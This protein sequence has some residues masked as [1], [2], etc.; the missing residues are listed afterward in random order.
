MRPRLLFPDHDL[1]EA[2]DLP[3]HAEDVAVDLGLD[4]LV[5]AMAGSDAYL[6]DVAQQVLLS[7]VTDPDVIAYRQA[8]LRD[9]LTNPQ[10][11]EQ[12][13]GLAM[14]AIAS[15]ADVYP[16]LGRNASS[17]LHR[18][19]Q[20]IEAMLEVLRELREL[21]DEQADA[22]GSEAFTH[23]FG[24]LRAE[25]DEDFFDTAED[26][27][28]RLRFPGGV[29]V[30]ARLGRGGRGTG[31]VLREPP[32]QRSWTR[33]VVAGVPGANVVEVANRDRSAVKA[34]TEL[35]ER[36]LEQVARSL[37]RSSQ[38]LSR[39]FA[40]LRREVG[41]YLG[42]IRL[43]DAL[44]RRGE[45]VFPEVAT[46]DEP[47]FV[48]AGLEDA[49]LRLRIDDP[50]V[51]NDVAA[52]GRRLVLITGAN[53]GG[54]STFLRA[55]GL[56]QLMLQSGLF[57]TARSFTA[58]PAAGLFTHFKRGEDPTM[59]SGKLDEELGRLS[60]IVD[61][62]GPGA[63]V[64]FNESF[65]STNEHEGSQIAQEVLRALLDAQVRVFFVTHGYDAAAAIVEHYRDDGVF[66]RAERQEGGERTYRLLEG[67]PEPTS[68]GMDL[69]EDVFR[70]R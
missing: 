34:L 10:V 14:H 17:S 22:F 63:M 43:H 41:F 11:T 25:L 68:Y 21:A 15:E 60:R 4:P 55:V 19:I 6:G 65:A 53:Q 8:A 7:P 48:A 58:T 29:V 26:Q 31:F 44:S 13:Y 3:E 30:G 42:A 28:E 32:L 69:Y 5:S 62:L 70:G 35:R 59:E 24:V 16:G 47:V 51:G 49:G 45:V 12:L 23:L 56:A 61:Q 2:T 33:R 57:V 27:L 64:L 9:C 67:A 38:H 52:Q 50:V 37:E 40:A 36:G 66:L 39:F 20:R 46:D 18:S 54:K 1:D